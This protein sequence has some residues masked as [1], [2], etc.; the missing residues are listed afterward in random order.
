MHLGTARELPCKTALITEGKKKMVDHAQVS[1]L[2]S[3]Q[4]CS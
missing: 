4:P 3:K 1:A 2:E